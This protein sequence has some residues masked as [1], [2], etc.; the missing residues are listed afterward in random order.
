MSFSLT[1]TAVSTPSTRVRRI[2]AF[3]V[4]FECYRHP[5][6]RV[7]VGWIEAFALPGFSFVLTVLTPPPPLAGTTQIQ[8]L[9]ISRVVA[10]DY[11]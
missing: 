1:A 3:G 7:R 5:S 10:Q 2:C 9:I 6:C 4:C 8:N 11:A